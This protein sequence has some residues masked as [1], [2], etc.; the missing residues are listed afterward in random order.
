MLDN[1]KHNDSC[2][3]YVCTDCKEELEYDEM[4]CPPVQGIHTSKE[5]LCH[6]C[7]AVRHDNLIA[8]Q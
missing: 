1:P 4:T 8:G 2:P 3:I 5:M 6:Q 7:F